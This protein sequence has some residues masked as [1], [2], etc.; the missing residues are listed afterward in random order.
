MLA[1]LETDPRNKMT[2]VFIRSENDVK[3]EDNINQGYQTD[4]MTYLFFLHLR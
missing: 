2:Q 4:R 1:T 3:S